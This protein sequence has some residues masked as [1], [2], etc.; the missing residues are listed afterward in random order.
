[1][2]FVFG[3]SPFGAHDQGSEG[4]SPVVDDYFDDNSDEDEQGA[5]PQ[6]GAPYSAQSHASSPG[7]AMDKIQARTAKSAKLENR[8]LVGQSIASY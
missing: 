7:G 4:K 5:T 6:T 3:A 2:G 1:M 8:K